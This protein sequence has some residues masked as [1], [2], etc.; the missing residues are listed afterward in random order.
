MKLA[1]VQ[2]GVE[3]RSSF[4]FLVS[5]II[6]GKSSCMRTYIEYATT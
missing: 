6:N 2:R 5:G 4:F 1:W 3:W